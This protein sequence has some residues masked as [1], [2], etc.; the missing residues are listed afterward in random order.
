MLQCL[1]PLT[2]C[3]FILTFNTS[4][5]PPTH[6]S[7]SET[8]ST[9][10]GIAGYTSAM[11]DR[12]VSP[13][14]SGRPVRNHHPLLDSLITLHFNFYMDVKYCRGRNVTCDSG[15]IIHMHAAQCK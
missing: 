15:L 2:C 11:I 7:L 10:D 3:C 5:S 4:S 1:C 14:P 6:V 13:Q 8:N 12:T 9:S